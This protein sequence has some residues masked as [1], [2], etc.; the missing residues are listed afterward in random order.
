MS[1]D[2]AV[3]A[4]VLEPEGVIDIDNEGG[5][6]EVGDDPAG[7]DDDGDGDVDGEPLGVEAEDGVDEGAGAGAKAI[8]RNMVPAGATATMLQ[9]VEHVA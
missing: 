6:V 1:V 2:D 5:S 3:A 9:H 4:A 8:P 7:K